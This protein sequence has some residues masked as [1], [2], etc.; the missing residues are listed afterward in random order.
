MVDFL[1]SCPC[2]IA[3]TRLSNLKAPMLGAHFHLNGRGVA[4]L[5]IQ[6]CHFQFVNVFRVGVDYLYSCVFLLV[7]FNMVYYVLISFD[8][9]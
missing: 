6:V 8:I 4:T 3:S 1:V 5:A 7:C 9:F 2:L